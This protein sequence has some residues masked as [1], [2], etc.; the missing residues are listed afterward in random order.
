MV[1]FMEFFFLHLFYVFDL[2]VVTLSLGLELGFSQAVNQEIAAVIIFLRMWRLVRAGHGVLTL[3]GERMSELRNK[4]RKNAVKFAK[5]TCD[6]KEYEFEMLCLEEL[7]DLNGIRHPNFSA[8]SRKYHRSGDVPRYDG[9]EALEEE[10]REMLR[11]W[12]ALAAEQNQRRVD[13]L[14]LTS[15]AAGGTGGGKKK[16]KGET[17]AS[18]HALESE[19]ELGDSYE[20]FLN[21]KKYAKK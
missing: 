5:L 13:L 12:L 17:R 1:A 10:E 20:E 3:E 7:L 6:V 18:S 21:W 19:A 15:R 11:D 16:E 2:V 4:I 9:G 14:R 8:H